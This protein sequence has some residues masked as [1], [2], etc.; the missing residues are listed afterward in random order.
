[1]IERINTIPDDVW[2]T[3]C[4][5]MFLYDGI[6]DSP[7]FKGFVEA[8]LELWGFNGGVFVS[9]GNEFD[10]FVSKAM[11]G[12][13]RMRDTMKEYMSMMLG[14]HNRLVV[15]IHEDNLSSLGFALKFGFEM[16]GYDGNK[17]VLEVA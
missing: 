12:R 11:R 9:N 3:M 13:W 8:G 1:L 2:E 17:I 5:T 4:E 14:R 7:G 16:I 10:L 15:K 6:S